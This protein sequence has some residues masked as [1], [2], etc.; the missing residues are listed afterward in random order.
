MSFLSGLPT[1][2]RKRRILMPTQA[3]IDESGIDGAGPIVVFAGFI[4][5][6]EQWAHFADEWRSALDGP[7]K[8]HT[9]KMKEAAAR[10]GEFAGWSV[11]ARNEL[12]LRLVGVIGHYPFTAIHTMMDVAGHREALKGP[13]K[14][15]GKAMRSLYFWPFQVTIMA[16]TYELME[17]NHTARFEIIFD[18]NNIFGPRAK[19]W[20]PIVRASAISLD[21]DAKPLMPIEPLF[22]SDT[23]FMPLQ[24]ADMLAWLL[25]QV[26]QMRPTQFDW[27]VAELGRSTPL[28]DHSQFISRERLEYQVSLSKDPAFATRVIQLI[29]QYGFRLEGDYP[30]SDA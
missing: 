3:W 18:E 19:R 14:E 1:A 2:A 20:Y 23:E 10:R 13:L 29:D 24:A 22:K 7:P 17:N 9:F 15:V 16:V 26:A 12:L 28:S 30:V 27:L 4:G 11:E 21:P 8:I 5:E 25:R 6:A